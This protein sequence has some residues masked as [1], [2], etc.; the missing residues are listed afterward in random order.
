M[1]RT[2]STVLETTKKNYFPVFIILAATIYFAQHLGVTLPEPVN[3]HL[4]D[5]L[6]MPLV[7]KT[8]LYSVRYVKSDDCIQL[9]LLLQIS[10]ALLFIIYFEGVLPSFD[11]RYTADPLDV[12]AYIAGLLFFMGIEGWER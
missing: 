7:L 9:P 11:A 8:C 10:T 2:F 12:I 3:N 6:C 5:F 4:N 1:K